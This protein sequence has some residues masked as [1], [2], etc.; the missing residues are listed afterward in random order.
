[1]IVSLSTLELLAGVGSAPLA[2]SS[3]TLTWSRYEVVP[4][5]AGSSTP[6]VMVHDAVVPATMVPISMICVVAVEA[7]PGR[8]GWATEMKVVPGGKVL[9]S[10]TLAAGAPPMFE[11][12]TT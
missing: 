11:V 10:T 5:G 7:A 1:M 4:A 12:S 3:A 2:A 9:V 8:H 6:T